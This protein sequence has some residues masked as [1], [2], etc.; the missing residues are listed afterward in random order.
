MSSG[1]RSSL[2]KI[3][4][5]CARAVAVLEVGAA[6]AADQ[7]R[8]AGEDAVAQEVAVGIVGVAGRI[9]NIERDALDLNLVA[10]GY[11][12]R[13]HVGFGLFAH[14]RDALVRSRSAPRPVMWS[15][16]RWVSSALIS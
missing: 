5:Y 14:H 12:H 11:T 1:R 9:Q 13:D 4:S 10:F 6:G 2:L 7:Q 3:E 8:V 15:A 16:W